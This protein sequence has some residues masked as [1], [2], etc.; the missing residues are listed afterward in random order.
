MV[1]A[2]LSIGTELTRGE[3]VDRNGPMLAARLTAMGFDIRE[4]CCVDD[5]FDR[6]ADTIARLAASASVLVATGGTGP[7][8]DDRTVPAV[9]KALG[10]GLVRDEDTL[11]T[12]RRRVQSSGRA[13][14]PALERLADVPEGAE[15]FPN[16]AGLTPPFRVTLGACTVFVLPGVPE[17][18]ERVFDEV[19]ARRF[20][21]LATPR[22]ERRVLRTIGCAEVQITERLQGVEEKF[23]G[24]SLALR[25]VPPE[26]DVKVIVR[27]GDPTRARALV[28]AAASEV[29]ARLG[30][31]VFG[32]GD[33]AFAAAVGRALRA[34]GYTLAVAE[35]CTGGLIG[36]ML[37]AVAGSSDYLLLDAVTYA[38]AAKERVLGVEPE[39]LRG[40][41]AVSAECVRA[42]A[43]GARRVS[44]ADIAVSVSGVAGPGGGSPERPV[45]TVWFGLS[46]DGDDDVTVVQ[47]HFKGD[48]A[49]VQRQAAYAALELVRARCQGPLPARMPSVCG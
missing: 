22:G 42:M 25:A 4:T 20:V 47:R 35:S 11:A 14:S 15:V 39:I 17:Q 29:R 19:L 45:G 46:A 31:A 43:L 40:H 27:D 3:V 30:D 28:D 41:G 49:A 2:I 9:A 5:D 7:T 10:V 38:N 37:T 24:V 6:I 13:P 23:P 32:E 34:R 12:I 26:V 16:P 21:R 1:A 33:D 48:R 36:A 18:A 8:S 44:G